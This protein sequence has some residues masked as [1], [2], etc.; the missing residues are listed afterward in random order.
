MKRSLLQSLLFAASGILAVMSS[1]ARAAYPDKPVTLVVSFAPG[2]MTDTVGRILATELGKK[3]GQTFVV[4]NKAG[5]AGQVGTEYVARQKNDGYT[6]LISATGH[7][8]GPAVSSNIRYQ[9][10]KDF[11][12]IAILARA[13]NLFVVNP[14]LPV[15][16]LSEFIAWERRKNPSPTDR[17]DSAGRLILAESCSGMSRACRWNTF[18]TKGP[19]LQPWP[20]SR[21]K[22]P[23]RFKTR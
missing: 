9:P 19:H 17:R 5:A 1:D 21:A 15:N 12:P 20:W 14:K 8:I 22:Y 6:L 7:V 16:N 2:G 4:E 10:V 11:E 3:F 13:P 18:R 23:L